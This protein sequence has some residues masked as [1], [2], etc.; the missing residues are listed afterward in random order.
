M[1]DFTVQD[2]GTIWTIETLT[3]AATEW[4]E[5]NVELP[6]YM[7]TAKAFHADWRQGR[8]IAEGMQADG[9]RM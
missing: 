1:R 5:T 9:L 7:G 4:V 8:A 3:D 2:H 6:D